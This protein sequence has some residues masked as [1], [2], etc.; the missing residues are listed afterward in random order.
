ML[1][2]PLL[3]LSLSCVITLN[4]PAEDD[5]PIPKEK[6]R[7]FDFWLGDWNVRNR[8]ANPDGSWRDG[9]L[10][11]ARVNKVLG[12]KAILEQ[13]TG[14]GSLGL[15]GFSLRTYDAE[16][17]RWEI[18]LNWHSGAPSSFSYMVGN[19]EDERGEF[20][21]PS[22]PKRTRFTFSKAKKNS[23][24]WDQALSADGK[25]WRTNWIMSFTRTAPPQDRDATNL[26]IQK[27]AKSVRGRFPQARQLDRLIG[28]WSGPA[29]RKRDDGS[30][31]TGSATR[32]VSSMIDGYGLL[33]VTD[34]SWGEQSLTAISF[35][36]TQARW[37]AVGMS[38]LEPDCHW[39]AGSLSGDSL[40]L[41]ELP[42]SD[43]RI[44]EVL[45]DV[46]TDSYSWTRE[47]RDENGRASVVVSANFKR[48]EPTGRIATVPTIPQGTSNLA[49][50]RALLSQQKF[51]Q[52]ETL[53]K[54]LAAKE[55]GDPRAI[56]LLGY[57]LHAQ[58]KYAQAMAAYRRSVTSPATKAGSEY[59]MA[60]I[61]S[62][63]GKTDDAFAHLDAAVK[64]GFSNIAQAA[65]DPDFA[66]IRED[67]RFEKYA[68][69]LVSDDQ[70]FTEPT[71]IIHKFVGEAAGDQFG[72]TARRAGDWDADGVTDF[73]ATAPTHAAGAGKIYVYS[74]KS[75]KLLMQK[76]GKPGEQFGNSAVGAGD[77]NGD[78]KPDLIVGAPNNAAAGNA[79][80][81]SGADGSLLHH[82]KGS[83][84]GDKFG[85]EVSELGDLNN[86]GH[87]DVFVGAMAGLGEQKRSGAAVVYSGRTGKPLFDLKGEQSGDGFGNAAGCAKNKDGSFTLAIGA[88]NAGPNN[89][90]RV[91]VYRI[92][93]AKPH[94]EFTIE[95]DR[96]SRNLG[97]MFISFPGD[98]D[99]DGFPD[100]YA[101]DFSDK[102]GAPG[103]GK[104]VVCSG[105]TGKQLLAITGKRPGEGLGT[106]PSDA[107]DVNQDGVGD[108]VIGAWQNNEAATSGGRVYLCDGKTGKQ[109]RTWTCRQ[110]GDT[111]G[112]DACGIGDV[113]GD[114]KIDFLLT[115]A[116]SPVKGPKT[117]RVF[118][119]AG[120]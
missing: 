83:Q 7:Q 27:P 99:G 64:A 113:D 70:L 46:A 90:G 44:N 28:V 78:G 73:V 41:N 16:Q 58:K 60:C 110:A 19:F 80:V 120:R 96:N 2:F 82:F 49:M 74:G 32:R 108:L 118:I 61:C 6:A 1:R 34:F 97:Q 68:P 36:L 94:R 116:W 59:N 63:Q 71:R 35:N 87:A 81:F 77:V 86:D 107:G 29:K 69:K 51:L 42:T 91:Y 92:R 98:S 66:N 100:I 24:Q 95:G 111:L 20:F 62:I 38:T 84:P 10:A 40:R 37:L 33:Q 93:E 75:G 76:K 56:Y 88:Q 109:L 89:R 31:E 67:K 112:F 14:Q 45:S 39:L 48:A 18:V 25:Q 8:H 55:N 57:T 30:W 15:R 65:A 102:T 79:Y 72:W 12:G 50:A 43:N 26:P 23:C 47:R 115:S 117:G 9:G 22:G 104:V 106:S 54:P 21:P 3:C 103:G 5:V 52:A 13:W 119:V 101:S 53:L 4:A 17:K 85:Y 11:K 105:K 114:G